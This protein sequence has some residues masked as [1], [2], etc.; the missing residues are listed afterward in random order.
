M[1]GKEKTFMSE[2]ECNALIREY[3]KLI[4]WDCKEECETDQ[5]LR[6]KQPPLVK[7]PMTDLSVT[8]AIG[9]PRDFTSLKI[10]TDLVKI[11]SERAS[12]R[13][14]SGEEISFE[15]LSFLL[16]A[17][18]GIKSIRGKRYATIRT[19]PSGGARHPFETYFAAL[20]VEGAEARTLSLSPH[21]TLR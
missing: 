19:V 2:G 5:M 12:H 14:Y 1:P 18:Q 20:H 15:T 7:A 21:D 17:T 8:S 9:L 4:R 3:R 6:R 11:F 16:W 10:G 13:V